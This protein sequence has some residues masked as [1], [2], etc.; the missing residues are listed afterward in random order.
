MELEEDGDEHSFSSTSKASA[1]FI[2]LEDEASLVSTED[3]FEERSLLDLF[4]G[5]STEAWPFCN[6]SSRLLSLFFGGVEVT[7]GR[8]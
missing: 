3:F 1:E 4:A 8:G 6:D 5:I 2:V 7:D